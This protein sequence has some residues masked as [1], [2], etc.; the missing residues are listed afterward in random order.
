MVITLLIAAASAYAAT[1]PQGLD[2]MQR[3]WEEKAQT[4]ALER[5]G[6][7]LRNLQAPKVADADLA[8][9]SAVTL[10]IGKK[11]ATL[12]DYTDQIITE[13][14]RLR[15]VVRDLEDGQAKLGRE[16]ELADPQKLDLKKLQQAVDA[17]EGLSK[18]MEE[19][20]REAKRLLD[21]MRDWNKERAELISRI[22]LLENRLAKLQDKEP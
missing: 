18:Q 1:S 19:K 3:L 15:R 21:R 13:V 10:T 16:L 14:R 6:N 11:T 12:S 8:L 5:I 2:E 7:E 20:D 17:I 22:S 4:R 9:V